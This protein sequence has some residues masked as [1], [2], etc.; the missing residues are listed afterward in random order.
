ME[1]LKVRDQSENLAAN[2]K[3]ILEWMLGKLWGEDVEDWVY[4]VQDRDQWRT[5]LKTEKELRVP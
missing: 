5:V 3:I 4:L 1:N 2:G